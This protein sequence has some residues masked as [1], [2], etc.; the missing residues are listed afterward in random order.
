MG[1][2][3]HR[4][5]RRHSTRFRFSSSIQKISDNELIKEKKLKVVA[6]FASMS[7]SMNVKKLAAYYFICI[8]LFV[9][10][11]LIFGMAVALA[12]GD[13]TFPVKVV[14]A[15]S[16]LMMAAAIFLDLVSTTAAAVRLGRYFTRTST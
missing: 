8:V 5:V 16:W 1:R 9:L 11:I 14:S 7:K 12:G 2:L 6:V 13:M 3:I 10:S 15:I 4:R